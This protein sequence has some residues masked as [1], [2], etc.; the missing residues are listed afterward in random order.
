VVFPGAQVKIF[1]DAS[2]EVRAMRR[3]IEMRQK[4]ME[5][6][7]AQVEAGIRERDHRDSNR[8]EAPL[9]QAADAVHVDTSPM[10]VDEVVSEL[11]R[12]A[13]E[14]LGKEVKA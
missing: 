10:G 6:D 4:G 8:A 5:A 13:G 1:L 14:R 12:I 9:R 2:P 11:L 7:P 3:V